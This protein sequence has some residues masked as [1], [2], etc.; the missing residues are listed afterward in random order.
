LQYGDVGL[1][2]VVFRV[3]D[4]GNAWSVELRGWR[5]VLGRE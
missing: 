3:E 1:D 2:D 5:V 4:G